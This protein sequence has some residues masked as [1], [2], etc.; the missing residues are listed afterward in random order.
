MIDDLIDGLD[1]PGKSA[2]AGHAGTGFTA[3]SPPHHPERNLPISGLVDALRV[4]FRTVAAQTPNREAAY[5]CPLR[6]SASR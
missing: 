6:L 2:P 1:A 3:G 4:N 5:L